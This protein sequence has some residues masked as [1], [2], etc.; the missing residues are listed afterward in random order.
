PAARV[1]CSIARASRSPPPRRWCRQPRTGRRRPRTTRSPSSR[2]RW[3]CLCAAMELDTRI[4][5]LCARAQRDPGKAYPTFA[6]ALTLFEQ[7]AWDSMAPERPLRYWQLIETGQAG[8]QPLIASALRADERIVNYIKGLNYLDDRL[9]PSLIELAPAN[10]GDRLPPSQAAAAA[11]IAAALG[12]D[13]AA[14]PL[15]ELLGTDG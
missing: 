6:L 4:A 5:G 10:P 15:I 3:C 2:R 13:K 9:A 7:P 1:P 8:A 11:T 14:P 12:R